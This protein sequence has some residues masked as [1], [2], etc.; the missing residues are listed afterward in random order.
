MQ[1]TSTEGPAAFKPETYRYRAF[2]S[3]SRADQKVVDDMF[4]RLSSFRTPNPLLKEVG[5]FGSPPRSLPIFLDR[6]SAQLG[7]TVPDRLRQAVIES[8]FLVLFCSE[9]SVRSEWVAREIEIFLEAHPPHHILPVFL[10]HS[11]QQA[12]QQLMPAPLAALGERAPIGGDLLADGGPRPVAHKLL[13][14]M[15]GFPQDRISR[16]QERADRQRRNLERAALGS[17]AVLATG[18]AGFAWKSKTDADKAARSLE[19]SLKSLESTAPFMGQL[20][21]DGRIR[22]RDLEPFA[23]HMSET[24]RSMTDGDLRPLPDLRF[25]FGQVLTSSAAFYATTGDNVARLADAERAYRTLKVFETDPGPDPQLKICAAALELAD[26]R[27]A[28]GDYPGAIAAAEACARV[29]TDELSYQQADADASARLHATRIAAMRMQAQLLR[30][31]SQFTDS[32]ARLSTAE[33]ADYLG[34]LA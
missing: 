6:K 2:L 28:D 9:A 4:R 16:E 33:S 21:R 22:T 10:R 26:A 13:G 12:P 25:G 14:A 3:Y 24:F 11:L 7:A 32:L 30:A 34:S 27:G 19:V 20:I 5:D 31:Q 17:I 15:L 8:A 1:R 23:N 18:A 29:A